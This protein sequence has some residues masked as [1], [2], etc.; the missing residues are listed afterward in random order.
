MAIQP[1]WFVVDCALD[2]PDSSLADGMCRTSGG[3]CTLRAAFQQAE[4][5]F[6]LNTI[7]LP[8]GVFELQRLANYGEYCCFGT[9]VA[10]GDL[11]VISGGDLTLLGA[12]RDKTII[13]GSYSQ[14]VEV[15]GEGVS[16]YPSGILQIG[17]ENVLGSGIDVVIE[18]VGIRDGVMQ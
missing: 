12:G 1:G 17:N 3:E 2:L 10:S 6:G 13:D 14:G 9:W 16:G 7:V 11:D 4:Y 8:E 18:D 15:P 5:A